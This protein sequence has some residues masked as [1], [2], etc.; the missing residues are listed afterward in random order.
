MFDSDDAVSYLDFTRAAT[1]VLLVIGIL[2]AVAAI[3]IIGA[4]HA[5]N[6]QPPAV[7]AGLTTPFTLGTLSIILHFQIHHPAHRAPMVGILPPAFGAIMLATTALG[8]LAAQ[9]RG[10][11][12]AREVCSSDLDLAKSG[13]GE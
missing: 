3:A 11:S 8:V 7:L 2:A 1:P 6:S 12:D 9:A 4:R 13:V 5:P 10:R